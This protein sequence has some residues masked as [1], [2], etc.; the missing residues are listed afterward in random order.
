MGYAPTEERYRVHRADCRCG[1][2]VSVGAMRARIARHLE[3]LSWRLSR[4]A[5]HL[6]DG[7]ASVE[8]EKQ[9][10]RLVAQDRLE[11]DLRQLQGRVR[12]QCG[13]DCDQH[14]EIG[15]IG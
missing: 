3:A 15:G 4:I 13:A 10:D 5:I 7:A 14:D 9:Y 1:L 12:H 11:A 8:A 2:R 6:D